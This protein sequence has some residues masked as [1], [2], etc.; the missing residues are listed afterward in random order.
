MA[1]AK[2]ARAIS[3][4][5]ACLTIDLDAMSGWV[6]RGMTTPTPVSRGEFGIIGA[7]RILALLDKY[8]IRSTWFVPGVVIGTYPEVCARIVEHG[9]EIAHHGW[10]HVPSATLSRAGREAAPRR[11][12]G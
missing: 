9:H 10:T 7:A 12:R 8:A 6:A 5:I 11:R 2:G 3:R 1:D 4:H